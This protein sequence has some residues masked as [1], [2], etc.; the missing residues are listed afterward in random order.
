MPFK[1]KSN[2]H[3]QCSPTTRTR[4]V[5][6]WR[7]YYYMVNILDKGDYAKLQEEC[8]D[9]SAD[10]LKVREKTI[11]GVWRCPGTNLHKQHTRIYCHYTNQQPYTSV[12]FFSVRITTSRSCSILVKTIHQLGRRRGGRGRIVVQRHTVPN[13][14]TLTAS[15]A[16]PSTWKSAVLT[17][18]LPIPLL[19]LHPYV[20]TKQGLF[21][22]LLTRTING[23][24]GSHKLPPGR[25]SRVPTLTSASHSGNIPYS[26]PIS[27]HTHENEYQS[28]VIWEYFYLLVLSPVPAWL[29]GG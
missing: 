14:D 27:L 28:K 12:S 4:S 15:R 22:S 18:P 20:E 5:Q 24:K 11:G 2:V 3:W 23:N 10:G 25:G 16:C 8:Y 19:Q 13:S 7:T 21:Y 1:F 17:Y 26:T 6:W 9:A 29:F